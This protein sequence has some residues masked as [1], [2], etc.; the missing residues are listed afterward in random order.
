MI[1][2]YPFIYNKIPSELYNASIV[3]IS[4]NYTNRPSGSGVEMITESIRRNPQVLYLDGMQSPPLEFNVEI[5]AE[6]GTINNIL[7]KINRRDK[8]IL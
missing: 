8:F 3:F 7:L 6:D 4:E 2:G 1:G 5:V